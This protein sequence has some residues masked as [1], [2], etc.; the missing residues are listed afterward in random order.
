M[1]DA[2]IVIQYE[3][4][5]AIDWQEE[6]G[7]KRVTLWIPGSLLNELDQLHF[8][9][10]TR[11]V[12]ERSARFIKSLE[13]SLDAYMAPGGL[14]IRPGVN[15]RLWATGLPTGARNTDHFD[16]AFTL[17]SLGLPV[18]IVTAD[19]GFRARARAWGFEVFT[20][21][22]RWLLRPEPT[23]REIETAERLRRAQLEQAPILALA[24]SG[25]GNPYELNLRSDP[26]GGEARDVEVVW[27]SVGGEVVT[28]RDVREN[29]DLRLG[30]DAAYR[31][32]VPGT[33]PPGE[34]LSL[35]LL[36]AVRPPLEVT[37]GIRAAGGAS[38]RDRL[39]SSDGGFTAAST[40]PADHVE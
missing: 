11:R 3:P 35:A 5:E 14:D 38:V 18:H 7:S 30:A 21:S 29:L 36:S 20:P 28:A 39:V 25:T 17:R 13:P 10:G 37:Y 9:G 19:L 26:E 8:E 15:L 31:Q 27:R 23:P 1:V 2:N 32:S 33:L 6:T 12:R 40:D 24:I 22:D 16:S 34:A 4:L